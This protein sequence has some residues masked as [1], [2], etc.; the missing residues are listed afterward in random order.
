MKSTTTLCFLLFYFLRTEILQCQQVEWARE[1][2]ILPKQQ[3]LGRIV[4]NQQMLALDRDGNTLI[5][6]TFKDT[7]TLADSARY[8]PGIHHYIAKLS[9]QGLVKWIRTSQVDFHGHTSVAADSSGS[10]YFRYRFINIAN[11]FEG[12]S[13]NGGSPKRW[14][15]ALWKLDANGSINW[16][17]ILATYRDTSG[18]NQPYYT[19]EGYRSAGSFGIDRSGNSYHYLP[20]TDSITAFG[21]KVLSKGARSAM[22]FKIDPSGERT[23]IRHMP[24]LDTLDTYSQFGEGGLNHGEGNSLAV[25]PSGHSYLVIRSYERV[26]FDDVAFEKINSSTN[27][28][29]LKVSPSGRAIWN[30]FFTQHMYSGD[31]RVMIGSDA[32]EN[33]YLLGSHSQQ[34]VFGNL[35]SPSLSLGLFKIDSAG[36]ALWLRRQHKPEHNVG[37]NSLVSMS[38]APRGDIALATR[39]R[40][41]LYFQSHFFLR[42]HRDRVQPVSTVIWTVNTHGNLQWLDMLDQGPQ[43]TPYDILIGRDREVIAYGEF[44]QFLVPADTLR[45]T[46]STD[47]SAIFI[48]KYSPFSITTSSPHSS[49]YCLGD[50]VRVGWRANAIAQSKNHFQAQLSDSSGVFNSNSRII[51]TVLSTDSAGEIH[52]LL[53]TDVP[54]DRSYRIRVISSEPVIEGV[55]EGPMFTIKGPP[56][57]SITARKP[58]TFCEGGSVGLE[59][60]GAVSYLWSTGDTSRTITTSENGSYTVR[61]YND[62]GCVGYDT[63][64]VTILPNPVATISASGPTSFCERGKV[65]L[66]ASEAAAYL[67]STGATTRS[68]TVDTTG[69]YFVRV[70]TKEG[71]TDASE[72]IAVTVLETPQVPTITREGN[73]LTSSADAYNQWYY[74]DSMIPGANDQTLIVDKGG[75]YHVRIELPTGCGARSEV[76]RI[77]SSVTRDVF[78]PQKIAVAADGRSFEFSSKKGGDLTIELLNLL[79]KTEALLYNG[80]SDLRINVNIP[81]GLAPGAYFLRFV[82]RGEVSSYKIIVK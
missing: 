15:T 11:S 62:I 74:Y 69:E 27:Y 52:A 4:R 31:P 81:S 2:S 77:I 5:T 40:D 43:N 68:I 65:T 48:V 54:A 24:R 30:Q 23:W 20:Y 8:Q 53:P 82:E 46:R 10:I 1:A 50:T 73:V 67:W 57:V 35:I 26:M 6:G 37:A 36:K 7:L 45:V 19:T 71:C 14:S 63:I 78:D 16:G 13:L 60:S 18:F 79:G 75:D 22:F 51:G 42:Q 34:I 66:T 70:T 9:R 21:N 49:S 58:T 3:D 25:T 47:T 32:F 76:T 56:S 17:Q 38:V 28:S 44:T 61:G 12:Q 64:A 29:I 33:L 55:T 41:T 80:P 59:G 39:I 72:E